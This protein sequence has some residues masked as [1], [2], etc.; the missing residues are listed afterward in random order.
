MRK[1][2]KEE[3]LM[4]RAIGLSRVAAG[5]TFLFGYIGNIRV[6]DTFGDWRDDEKRRKKEEDS[7]MPVRHRTDSTT[8]TFLSAG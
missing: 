7:A 2:E 4:L 1:K 6:F 8:L 3:I 5:F